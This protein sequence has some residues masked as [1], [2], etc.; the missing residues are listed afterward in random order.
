MKKQ[1]EDASRDRA[2]DRDK[3]RDRW[4]G[5]DEKSW[6]WKPGRYQ[7]AGR[8]A[9]RTSCP[10]PTG[11]CPGLGKGQPCGASQGQT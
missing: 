3:D 7:G 1:P 4:R 5:Q 9:L 10:A 11:G 2:G 6:E 8:T